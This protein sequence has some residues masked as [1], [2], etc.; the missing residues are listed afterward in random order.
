MNV[1][2]VF[3][4]CSRGRKRHNSSMDAPSSS[5]AGSHLQW[6]LEE[7]RDR[8]T[9]RKVICTEMLLVREIDAKFES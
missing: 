2:E 9:L 7:P 3:H 8:A 6:M 1:I 4:A 5:N